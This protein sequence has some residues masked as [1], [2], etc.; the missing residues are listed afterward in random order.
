[1]EFSSKLSL[2]TPESWNCPCAHAT[3]ECDNR[4]KPQI[5]QQS[6]GAELRTGLQPALPLFQAV[7]MML[8][9]QEA[10]RL[11]VQQT[12]SLQHRVSDTG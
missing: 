4:E 10:V 8:G 5:M 12:M 2:V 6:G 9:R 7:Q 11:N 1:M 3:A